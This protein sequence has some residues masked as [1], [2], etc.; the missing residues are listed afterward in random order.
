MKRLFN[1]IPCIKGERIVL[2]KITPE[3]TEALREMASSEEIY[4]YE[5]AFLFERLYDAEY[6]IE[7]LYDH[8]LNQSL[9]LGIFLEEEFC[10][11]AELYN[12]RDNIHSVS[13]G[14]RLLKR[15]WGRGLGPEAVK[16]LVDYIHSETDIETIAASSMPA[17][18]GSAGLL[19][20]CGFTLLES[21]AEE[22]WGYEKPLTTYKWII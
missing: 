19:K 18:R 20:K 6:V 4:K 7:H 8:N 3:Y 21:E 16:M 9:F 15:Y 14:C 5:P 12:F 17:N 13:I 11:I 22:D 1:E 10:G 2:K